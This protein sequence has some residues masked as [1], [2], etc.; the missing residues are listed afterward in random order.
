MAVKE[1]ESQKA[2]FNEA[3][4][5]ETVAATVAAD[6]FVFILKESDEYTF[7]L[8]EN[9]S[10][11]TSA[12]VNVKAPTNGSYAAADTDISVELAAGKKAIVR[13]ESA[14]YANTDGTVKIIPSSTDVKVAVVD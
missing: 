4:V 2:E 14:K 8:I 3:T 11:T 10:A 12:T 13:F 7:I 5:I 1:V 6:G 9:T